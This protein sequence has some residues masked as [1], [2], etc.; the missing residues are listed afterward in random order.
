[1]PFRA[2]L[3]AACCAFAL[4]P[5]VSIAAVAAPANP[6]AVPSTLPLEAP[7]FDQI[8]DTDYEPALEEGMKQ[9]IAEIEAIANAKAAPTFENTIVAMEKSGRML[10]RAALTFS[11]WCKPTPRHAG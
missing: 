5:S 10:D 4:L 9:Q 7:R 8:K 1:M 2:G 11:R 3:L 6:L